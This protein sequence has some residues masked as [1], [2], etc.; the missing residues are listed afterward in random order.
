MA[1]AM[2]PPSPTPKHAA[3][4][5]IVGAGIAGLWLHHTLRKKG[6]NA[7]LLE[8]NAIGSGQTIASQGIIHSGLKYAIAGQVSALAK[9]ISAMPD[10]W[11]AALRGEGEIDLSAAKFHS[12]S[13]YMLIPSG[14]MGGLV[15]MVATK[16]LGDSVDDIAKS[17]WPDSLKQAGF[18]GRMIFMGEPVL[19]IPS[20]LEA[21]ATPYIDSV[22]R[23]TSQES[24][25][26]P[27]FLRKHGITAR[28]IIYTAAASNHL[29]ASASK[30]DKGLATQK[31]PLLMGMM[32][33]AP[34]PLYAHL[35]GSSDKPI[36]SIT[37]HACED[38]T[39]IWYLG[40]GVAERNKEANPKD[41]IKAAKNGFEKYLPGVD[42]SQVQWAALPIDRIEGKSDKEGW[43]PDTPTIH[44]G[45]NCYYCWP[46]KLTFAPL[47]TQRILEKL[48]EESLMALNQT[49][50]W[51]FLAEA[52]FTK[53]PWDTA[54]WRDA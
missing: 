28:K 10:L 14:F 18:K 46:T 16:A 20:V 24:Q 44:E 43:M 40:G 7:L 47:L 51:S 6:Y 35:I 25:D 19:D 36:A 34:F 32:K 48:E 50:D 2:T 53:K 22:R 52:P 29:A 31:R 23:I 54:I 4:I 12:Q 8:N 39:L 9:N 17:D 42:L 15:K 21:L 49:S 1:N 37:T 5:V 11:R 30:H 38:G 26:I 45:D 27:S 13:Q 3:D 41:M 33:P